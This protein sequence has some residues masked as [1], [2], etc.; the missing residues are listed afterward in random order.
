MASPSAVQNGRPGRPAAASDQV[1]IVEDRAAVRAGA[2]E[3]EL[4]ES[5]A[6]ALFNGDNDLDDV[7]RV[8]AEILA[9]RVGRRPS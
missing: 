5:Q 3:L 7:K 6:G 4:T 1:E 8:G 9:R 2:M